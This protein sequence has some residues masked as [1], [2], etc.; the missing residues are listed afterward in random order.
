L[1]FSCAFKKEIENNRIVKIILTA[2]ILR[3]TDFFIIF[4]G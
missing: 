3:K 1:L 4:I 2:E